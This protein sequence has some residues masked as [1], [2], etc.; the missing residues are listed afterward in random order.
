MT[1]GRP[2]LDLIGKKFGR[3]TVVSK[4]DQRKR[5]NVVWQCLCVCG[6]TVLRQSGRLDDKRLRSCGCYQKEVFKTRSD[7]CK[8]HGLT[9]TPEWNTWVGMKTRCY[10]K[11]SKDYR[12]WGARGIRI[13]RRWRGPNGFINFLNDMGKKPSRKHSIDRI[14]NN[15]NYEPLNCRWATATEQI[16]NRRPL[17]K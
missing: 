4:T 8:T 11:N 15:G 7:A 17:S 6:N 16:Q 1:M 5:D 9:G 12:N 2:S 3:L 10:D 14:D 13:C